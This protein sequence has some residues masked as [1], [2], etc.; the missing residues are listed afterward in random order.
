M[1]ASLIS[2]AFFSLLSG[3]ILLAQ[4]SSIITTVAGNGT[5]GYSADDVAATTSE[6]NL[7]VFVATDAAG[8][9]YIADQNNNRI[10]KV[11][12]TGVITTVAGTGTAGFFGDGGP[13]VMA[14]L[15]S[16]TGVFVD[17][18][19]N[20]LIADVG[21]YRIRKVDTSG[22]ITTVAGS[23]IRGSGGDGGPATSAQFYNAVRCV[24]D[25]SNNLYIADQSNHRVREV[26]GTGTITTIAGT[27]AEG[28]QWRWWCGY[29]R[30]SW[31]IRRRVAIDNPVILHRGPVQPA[32]PQGGSQRGLSRRLRN[33]QAGFSGDG[34][35]ATSA[36]LNYP[37]GLVV[38]SS[39]NIFLCDDV[40][41]RVR[42]ISAAGVITT[43]AGDGT[44]GFSGRQWSGDERGFERTVR[45]RDLFIRGR[46]G[47][48]LREPADPVD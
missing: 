30:P 34:G 14:Q 45:Y 22:V 15:N 36:S 25:A 3:G 35:Q 2:R 37:G 32:H 17:R 10:R 41:F 8:N 21:N 31:T 27:G 33:G 40:N 38:D 1:R 13:A 6:L 23:G 28:V 19:G 11:N 48:G 18:G 44:Q 29:G 16:P 7:P 9:F 4:T 5:A 12:V 20:I 24:S 43:V 46:V 26:D 39:G 42:E 47:G